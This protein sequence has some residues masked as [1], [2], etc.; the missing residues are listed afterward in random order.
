LKRPDD[1]DIEDAERLTQTA[2]EQISENKAFRDIANHFAQIRYSHLVPQII[3][4]PS[5]TGAVGGDPFGSDFIARVNAQSRRTRSAWLKRIQD[6]LSLAVPQFESLEITTDVGGVPHL[7]AGYRNWRKAPSYQ[8]ERDFSDGT[9]RL[10]GLLWSLVELPAGG[11][12]LLEEPEL[13]LNAEVVRILPSSLATAQR[14]RLDSQVILTTHATGLLSDPG[15]APSEVLLLEPT[16]DGTKG[17]VLSHDSRVM[18]EV[19]AGVTINDAVADRLRPEGVEQLALF[20]FV[21]R[22]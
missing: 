8:D 11:T 16:V 21:D 9:L 15:I 12:L 5:S 10:L 20:G 14:N 2:L 1:H 18:A 4:D 19:D 13:S 6:A 7:R 3:R 22:R 17:L